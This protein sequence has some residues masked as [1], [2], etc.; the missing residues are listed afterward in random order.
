MDT[1]MIQYHDRLQEI[2]N[3]GYLAG[4]RT[5]EPALTLPYG[6]I[7]RF[8]M[9]EGFPAV[10]TK[11]LYFDGCKGEYIGFLRGLTNSDEFAALGCKWW[12]KDANENTQW[13]GSKYRTGEG[14]LGRIYGAQ[15]RRWRQWDGTFLDQVQNAL[16]LIR[17]NPENR[18]IIISAW[19]PDEFQH[20]ALP[21]CHVLYR[22]QVDKDRGEL[23]MSVYQRSSDMFLGVPMNI[24]GGALMLHIFANATG[25]TPRWFT[26]HLDDTHIYLNAVDAV[27]EQ[28]GNPHY[29]APK[30]QIDRDMFGLDAN[31]VAL[32]RPD[33]IQ[34]LDYQYTPLVNKVEMVTG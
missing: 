34:L 22:F 16:A 28:L 10:T 13:L 33:Q 19:R 27:R 31:E 30:L 4:N 25:L 7:F 14:D 5:T 6:A 29:P 15:W 20:M 11:N 18:R 24:A 2:L 9:Q 12:A 32:I 17:H 21:P 1:T 26:H 3:H 8:D 23:H